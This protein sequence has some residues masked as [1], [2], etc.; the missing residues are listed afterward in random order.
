MYLDTLQDTNILQPHNGWL[1][2]SEELCS[3]AQS[4]APAEE[5]GNKWELCEQ[6]E[7]EEAAQLDGFGGHN[8][9]MH[10]PA[11]SPAANSYLHLGVWDLKCNPFLAIVNAPSPLFGEGIYEDIWEAV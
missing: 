4:W 5:Q 1:R 8:F 11:S 10:T 3:F 7:L 6:K 2:A 9:E